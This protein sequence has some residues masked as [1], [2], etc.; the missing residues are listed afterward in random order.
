MPLEP[1]V[2][3]TWAPASLVTP[4]IVPRAPGV[5]STHDEGRPLP[6]Q[7]DRRDLRP[8][9]RAVRR[10]A[11]GR[12]HDAGHHRPRR[13]DDRLL[14][15]RHR[16]AH[17]GRQRDP[18]AAPGLRA[19][20]RPRPGGRRGDGG[21]ARAQRRPRRRGRAL[22]GPQR[23]RQP[24]A[25]HPGLLRPRAPP[26]RPRTGRRSAPRLA[27]VPQALD[28]FRTDPPGRRAPGHRRRPAP[29]RRLRAA[30]RHLGRGQRRR[31]PVLP[32]AGR[33]A[34]RVGDRRHGLARPPRR[35]RRPR[36]AGLRGVRP[37]PRRR[38]PAPRGRGRRRGR[39]PL[40]AVGPGVERHR[41]RPGRHVR[42]GM[43]RAAPHRARDA[44]RRRADHARPHRPRGDR[45]PRARPHAHDRGRRRVP[46]VAP[47]P[48]RLARSTRSTACTSTSPSR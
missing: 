12:G 11:P 30:G 32:H 7:R 23:A 33:E 5:R 24:D 19:R 13:P 16:G 28:G 26:R 27:L 36:D 15:R 31:H 44:A 21:A 43:G 1:P 48:A 6:G 35:R 47:G 17:P 46:R 2:I 25:A 39:H 42:V 10:A 41:A 4:R 40:R 22:P 9:R 29:G 3:S 38:V 20:H 8:V 14:P 45:P 34:R 37:L 18:R